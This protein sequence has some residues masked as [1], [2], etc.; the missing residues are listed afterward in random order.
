MYTHYLKHSQDLAYHYSILQFTTGFSGSYA[1]QQEVMQRLQA[2][3]G[4][5]LPLFHAVPLE[6]L[7][8]QAIEDR[9]LLFILV[10]KS[11]SSHQLRR[12]V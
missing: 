9:K 4:N 5:A 8:R 12:F 2:E 3:C 11:Q 6:S 10:L 1:R 7:I